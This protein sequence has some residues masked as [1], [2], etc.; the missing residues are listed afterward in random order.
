MSLFLF[1]DEDIS[2]RYTN[3]L[4]SSIER[5]LPSLVIS[6][7]YEDYILLHMILYVAIRTH[8]NVRYYI[9]LWLQPHFWFFIDSRA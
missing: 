1:I 9:H 3:C 2:T 4:S 6:K 8:N 5:R 7:E